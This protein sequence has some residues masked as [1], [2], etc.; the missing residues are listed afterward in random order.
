MSKC[1]KCNNEFEP[2]KGLVNYCSL[3]CRNSRIWSEEDK[4]KK[5]N[6][7]KNSEKIKIANK[8][9]GIN[10]T[11]IKIEKNCKTCGSSMLLMPSKSH[12]NFCCVD[13]YLKSDDIKKTGG[14]RKGSGV[15]KSGWY[16]GYWCDSSWELAW[17]IYNL[18]HNI[19]FKR[20]K[21]SFEYKLNN[22]KYKY[23]P[24]FIIMGIY[25][26]IKGY[27]NNTTIQ[28]LKYFKEKIVIIGK[29]EIKPF[30]K[31]VV[32]KYGN[33]YIR[34]YENN[35]HNVLTKICPI[36]GGPCKEKNVVC[37]RVCAGKLV[38]IKK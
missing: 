20:N 10:R 19:E 8:L 26:E 25:Y 12:K 35:P 13:C 15:G 7:A 2:S 21:K 23:Y 6:S 32:D 22:K 31:Y 36:C 30:I 3:E 38:K 18:E 14:Y 11:K 9:I 29:N 28:K 1:K 37:S 5:S 33:D 16:K 4:L 17:V 27:V 34:L 24:D